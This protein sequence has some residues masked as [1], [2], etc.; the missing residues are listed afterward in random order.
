MTFDLMPHIGRIG[1]IHYALGYGGH[2]VS[3]AT[4]LG[5]EIGLILAGK[6]QRSP[7]VE[8]AHPTRFYYRGRPWFLPFAAWYFRALDWAS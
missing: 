4:Y 6:I 8:I 7:F 5:T 2:G 3:I 1:G